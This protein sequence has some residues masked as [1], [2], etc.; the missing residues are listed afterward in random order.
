MGTVNV[1][2]GLVKFIW[3]DVKMEHVLPN[4]SSTVGPK[5]RHERFVEKVTLREACV[6]GVKG[7]KEEGELNGIVLSL[8]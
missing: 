6:A 4:P 8:P 2:C 1:F 7:L 3:T 5:L